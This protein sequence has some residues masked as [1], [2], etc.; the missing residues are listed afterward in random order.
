MPNIDNINGIDEDDISH[1]N[2]GAASLYTSKNGDTWVHTPPSYSG[3]FLIVGGGG[4]GNNQGY[5]F[6]NGGGGAGGLRTS[7]AGGSGGAGPS[8]AQITFASGVVYTVTVGAGNNTASVTAEPSSIIGTAVSITSIGGG[9]GAMD[10]TPPQPLA[11]VG[12]SGG[13]GI[14]RAPGGAHQTGAA[15]TEFQ[16][17]GGGDATLNTPRE[18]SGGGGGAAEAGHDCGSPSGTDA[19]GGAGKAVSITGTSYYWAGGGGGALS[20]SCGRWCRCP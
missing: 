11:T 6:M 7:W 13:G 15:G 1:Y 12:G 20:S 4:A 2:G 16:G 3:H 9:A 18:P 8:E 17:F 5:G 19:D 10:S 14:G